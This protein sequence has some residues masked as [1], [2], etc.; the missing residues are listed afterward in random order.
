MKDAKDLICCNKFSVTLGTTVL[1]V[2][3]SLALAVTITLPLIA[4]TAHAQTFSVLSNFGVN[5][6]DPQNPF[7]GPIAQGRDGAMYTTSWSGGTSGAGTVFKITSA[8]TL[9]VL[10]NL[11]PPTT[12]Y[13][14]FGGLTL[15][16]D[17]NF[18]GTTS[19]G[20]PGGWGTLFKIT[21]SG[22]MK[23]LYSFSND[24]NGSS[25]TSPPI[26]GVDGN[27]YGTTSASFG[28]SQG[29]GTIYKITPTGE[30]STLYQ[31]S[32]VDGQWP[33]ASMLLASDGNFYG[34]CY[35]GG[36][37]GF[38]TVYKITPAGKLTTIYNFDGT[39]GIW[40]AAGLVEAD[41]K[42][43]YG[44]TLDG[45]AN[46]SGVI[47]KISPAGKLTAIHDFDPTTSIGYRSGLV[48]ATDGNFYGV[49]PDGGLFGY[50]FIYKV[51]RDGEFS[52]VYTFDGI[53]GARP[54]TSFLQHTNGLLYGDTSYGGTYDWGV[55]DQLEIGAGPF[56]NLLPG[57]G[58]I[59]KNIGVLGQN[60]TATTN[61]SFG[62]VSATFTVV[63]DTY[64]EAIVPDGAQTGSVTVT[65]PTGTLSS[66]TPFR[67]T[68][69]I[70]SFN[71]TSGAVGTPVVITGTGFMQ[72]L[73]VGFGGTPA[74]SFSI[75][76]D[77]QVT[78]VVPSGAQTGKIAI[79]TQ[80]GH[81]TGAM[82]FTVTP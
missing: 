29:F 14:P 62:G 71:P 80:G 82:T 22:K 19:V 67:V 60:L 57:A 33:W 40:P 8:G 56:V 1:L 65:A 15:A 17:G 52:V 28:G 81:D 69:K 46:N 41:D 34:T 5:R 68:P 76:S 6:G 25:P 30:F 26:Q 64:L 77:S 7:L 21:P 45:G 74:T 18:Y 61:V 37:S 55:F 47:F 73:R 79:A 51:T 70:L 10:F 72:T 66:K 16:M 13:A 27:L 11:S 35:T 54:T 49:V 43:F 44:T 53:T 24:S 32:G 2:T 31:F 50:G 4:T 39:H 58:H 3:I 48:Q 59:G 36:T 63:S 38:G 42:T 78:A 23:V 75:D 12:G 9:R 20:G